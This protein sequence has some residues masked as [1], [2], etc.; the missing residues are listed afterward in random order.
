MLSIRRQL[1][2]TQ[3][4]SWIITAVLGALVIVGIVRQV[5]F[6][7]QISGREERQLALERI[8][9]GVLGLSNAL[10]NYAITGSIGDI[11]IFRS[12]KIALEK[13]LSEQKIEAADRI[14]RKLQTWTREYAV[15]VI[16]ARNSGQAFA[17]L[18][19]ANNLGLETALFDDMQANL[20]RARSD[21]H[22]ELELQ[23]DQRGRESTGLV[24]LTAI[25]MIG[26]LGPSILGWFLVTSR[27]SDALERLEIAA[28]KL[29]EGDLS[30]RV[31]ETGPLEVQRLGLSLN[32]LAD[33]LELSR[34]DLEARNDQLEQYASSLER[35]AVFERS[36]A[37]ALT[38]FTSSR[39][40]AHTLQEVMHLLAVDHG[41][42][43]G[44]IYRYL[45]S[46]QRFELAVTRGGVRGLQDHFHLDDGLVGQAVLDRR[47]I[48][49][50]DAPLLTVQTGLAQAAARFTALVPV[51]YQDRIIGALALAHTQRPDASTIGF[52]EQLAQQLGI[53][54]QNLE[55]YANLQRLSLELQARQDE[56]EVKNR[57][58]ERADRLKTEFLANMSHELR[59]PLNAV[60]GFSQ[61]LEQQYFG[62]LNDKQLE[63]IHEIEGAGGHLLDLIND[64]LD[65]SKIEAGRMELEL[66]H[67]ELAELLESCARLVRERA[68]RAGLDLTLEVVP[69]LCV[70]GDKRKLK[71]VIVNL[72]S[73][74]V[75]F[76]PTGGRVTL[77][78]FPLRRG[79]D[80]RDGDIEIS[81]EDT[82]IG[83]P[84]EDQERLFTPFTQV[85]GSL[86]RRHEGT[87]LGLA[88]SKRLTE[89]HG[90]VIDV[91][92][93]PGQG[94]IFSLRLHA[95]VNVP[96]FPMP[97]PIL[98]TSRESEHVRET[99][100]EMLERQATRPS[101]PNPE[102][103][104]ET[105]LET[106]LQQKPDTDR[107][108]TDRIN[109]DRINTDRI[110]TDRIDTDRIDTN[111]PLI[112]IVEDDGLQAAEIASHLE[113]AGFRTARAHDGEHGLERARA[114][115]PVAI[116]LDIVM[117]N[118]DGW[119][120]LEEHDRDE[121]LRK[122][123]VIV[124][125]VSADLKGRT[126]HDLTPTIS[127]S[128]QKPVTREALMDAIIKIGLPQP[129]K[130]TPVP[131]KVEALQIPS[132]DRRKNR[133]PGP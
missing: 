56:I 59:T 131:L 14:A 27:V 6:A 97:E 41:F 1:I 118:M 94:S 71:Q 66:E 133:R 11:E 28:N 3:T 17:L 49:L 89:L 104:L 13:N 4:F 106:Q 38:V 132:R 90:G 121:D 20:D 77:K 21:V 23:R 48:I 110:D 68:T 116:T 92:S 109:T 52:L 111:A 95:T 25:W 24:W 30:V 123:P 32:N 117:P 103:K 84:L 129:R 80:V 22:L 58:L 124:V 54:L 75:K 78:A 53:T 107:I 105:K 35:S 72:L 60:I 67:L 2:R 63:Y 127:G 101:E 85:D 76:T 19:I 126:H 50:E 86:A 130:V 43:V 91:R 33:Q 31:N 102:K 37:K 12:Q 9:G 108:N 81:V 45:E 70:S 51:L 120:F 10:R 47:T 7:A 65:L 88:L 5:N 18:K 36:V 100:Q 96:E 83:I 79:A 42:E 122:I 82:G 26:A 39:D 44:A 46:E 114:L 57:D 98:E 113:A 112:L 115:R 8:A 16:Q 74:A 55:Q 64:I 34:A 125:S 99:R 119:A 93:A 61:L 128:V 40:R 69:G 15:P 62:E 87:G 29:A 73:N